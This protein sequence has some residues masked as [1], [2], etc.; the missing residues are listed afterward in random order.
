M[1][2]NGHGRRGLPTPAVRRPVGK[3]VVPGEVGRWGVAEGAVGR[4]LQRPRAR[5]ADERCLE[6]VTVRIGI[7]GE[8]PWRRDV[9]DRDGVRSEAVGHGHRRGIRCLDPV[10]C[11]ALAGL[12]KRGLGVAGGEGLIPGARQGQ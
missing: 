4:Q 7:V 5:A 11:G 6:R 12:E 9:E 8:D 2:R 1:H 10:G 3:G